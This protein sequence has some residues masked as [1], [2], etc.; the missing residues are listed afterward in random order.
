MLTN[1]TTST[2]VQNTGYS[3]TLL[4]GTLQSSNFNHYDGSIL[5]N[6][7]LTFSTINLKTIMQNKVAVFKVTRNDKNEIKSTEFIK[8]MWVETQTGQTVEFEVARDKDLADYKAEDLSIR[9]IYTIT[10]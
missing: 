3:G 1:T 7:T 2:Y 10:F 8:E 4:S 9:T 5:P 6:T